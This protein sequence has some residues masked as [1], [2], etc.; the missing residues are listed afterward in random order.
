M[1]AK[2]KEIITELVKYAKAV[3]LNGHTGVKDILK[4]L[5][6]QT[7]KLLKK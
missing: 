3:G 1:T 2:E 6:N 4:D 7:E 5:I